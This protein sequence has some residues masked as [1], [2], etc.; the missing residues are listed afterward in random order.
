MLMAMGHDYRV[1]NSNRGWISM[2]EVFLKARF[3]RF[4]L[5]VLRL[6]VP[7]TAWLQTI[8]YGR[9]YTGPEAK[10]AN[11]VDDVASDSSTTLERAVELARQMASKGPFDRQA[12]TNLKQDL[13]QRALEHCYTNGYENYVTPWKHIISHL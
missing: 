1:Q 13:Y 12:V 10:A 4:L 8:V 11:L 7:N 6:K 9:R 3:P 2:N 5:E